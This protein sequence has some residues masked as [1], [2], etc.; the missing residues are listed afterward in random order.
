M[1]T[2]ARDLDP[3]RR[4]RAC[5]PFFIMF[6][7]LAAAAQAQARVTQYN[8]NS[9]HPNS[10]TANYPE[11]DCT[12]LASTYAIAANGVTLT[13]STGANSPFQII[14][15]TLRNDCSITADFPEGTKALAVNTITK[16][17]RP[18]LTIDFSEGVTEVEFQAQIFG[19]GTERFTFEVFN[20]AE[21]LAV[22][23]VEDQMDYTQSGRRG[24]LGAR[25]A[26]ADL[27]TRI[28][29]WAEFPDDAKHNEAVSNKFAIGP[30]SFQLRRN[31]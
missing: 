19:F 27:I 9:I 29:I 12:V 11:E 13:F 5:V 16:A 8:R 2:N 14:R 10:V 25:A 7:G 3:A 20:G 23:A 24:Y 28:R 17:A 31:D 26:G 1:R 18:P 21:S 15:Q 22:F 6:L 30:V 4:L